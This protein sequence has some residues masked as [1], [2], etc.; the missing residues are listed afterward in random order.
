M[1]L[2]ERV[3]VQ[4]DGN[5]VPVYGLQPGQTYYIAEEPPLH[6]GDFTILGYELRSSTGAYHYIRQTVIAF[7]LP[8]LSGGQDLEISV[9]CDNMTDDLTVIPEEPPKNNPPVFDPDEVPVV[10][11]PPPASGP[12]T[13]DSSGSIRLW[14]A[15]MIFSAFGLRYLLLLRPRRNI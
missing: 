12:Q 1:N 14:A 4:A 10:D 7:R 15:I 2:I 13:G 11:I 3:I 5:P 9:R 6:P 8:A